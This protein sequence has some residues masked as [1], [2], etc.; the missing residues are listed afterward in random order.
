LW[1]LGIS[2]IDFSIHGNLRE[3]LAFASITRE[4]GGYRPLIE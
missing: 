4:T 2:S 1:L 3:F